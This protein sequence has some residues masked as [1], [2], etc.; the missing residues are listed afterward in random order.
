M[1]GFELILGIVPVLVL[2]VF[3]FATSVRILRE[4]ERA[5]IF[6]LGR[7]SA[8]IFNPGGDGSGPGLG[9]SHSAGRP[10]GES[11]P[12]DRHHGRAA[13]GCDHPGQRVGEGERRQLLPGAGCH[14]GG[15]QRPGLSLCLPIAVQ[16]RYLQ[17][18]REVASERNITTYS[19]HP[20]L[21]LFTPLLRAFA[22]AEPP[23]G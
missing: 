23:K 15:D 22:A 17:T 16:L 13:A 8:A 10:N 18:M 1:G 11:Q 4:Y 3:I 21:D 7:R 2:A 19:F 20:L 14:Q 6:R 5:V 12:A 9:A